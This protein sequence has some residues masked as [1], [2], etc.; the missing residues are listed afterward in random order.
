MKD[1]YFVFADRDIEYTIITLLKERCNSLGIRPISY[2]KFKYGLKDSGCLKLSVNILRPKLNKYHHALVILDRDGCGKE[3]MEAVEIETEL[4][5]ELQ[6]NGWDSNNAKVIVIDPELEAWIWNGSDEL[7]K[8]LDWSGNYKSIEKFLVTEEILNPG[9]IKPD[10]PKTAFRAVLRKCQVP[11]SS[12][13]Y[14]K[15]AEKVSLSTCTDR[16][17]NKFKETLTNWFSE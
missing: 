8:V 17:F 14:R 4:E 13:I 7:P 6:K 16:S 9:Q 15:I 5:N 2:D 12:R 11:H 10:D 1:I 3:S